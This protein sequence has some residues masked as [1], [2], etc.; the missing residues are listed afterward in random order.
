M[1]FP[2]RP[3]ATPLVAGAFATMAVTGTTMFFHVET[4][5]A[6]GLHEW[7]GWLLLGA[8]A[9]HLALNWRAF[10]CYLKR[11]LALAIMGAGVAAALATLLPVGPR[12]GGPGAVIAAVAEAPVPVL[13]ELAGR[14]EA[15]VIADLVAAGFATA[16]ARSTV[17]QLAGDDIGRQLGVLSAV[18]AAD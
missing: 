11:P 15:A 12:T 3:W 10:R 5:L 7:L 6:K 13:A 1:S 14:T 16:D 17:A 2:L 8:G 18:I 4:L 9:A